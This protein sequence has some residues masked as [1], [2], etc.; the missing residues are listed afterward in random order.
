MKFKAMEYRKIVL[1]IP[2]DSVQ[3][4]FPE[5]W[6]DKAG[7]ASDIIEWTDWHTAKLFHSEDSRVKAVRFPY[8]RFTCDVE[9]LIDDPMEAIGQGILYANFHGHHRHLT[10]DQEKSLMALYFD[11]I[12]A[13]KAELTSDS[14]IIDCHSF[15]E[16][17]GP[18]VDI[19][20]GYNEDWSKPPIGVIELVCNTFTNAGYHVACNYPYSN[21]ISPKIDFPYPSLMIEINKALYLDGA[22]IKANAF[23]K[24]QSTLDSL[25]SALLYAID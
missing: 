16:H 22:A 9:R 21:S 10:H 5:A 4:L 18:D 17:V 14:L 1:N 23:K 19:C 13:L 8:S 12:N 20:I 11:H 15:P 24:L 2:H 25:Y 7:L 6:A 3:M